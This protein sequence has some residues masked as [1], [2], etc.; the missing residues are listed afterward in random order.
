MRIIVCETKSEDKAEKKTLAELRKL[1][2]KC[3]ICG[4]KADISHDVIDGADYGYSVGCQSFHLRDGI[5]GISE[6]YDPLAPRF[7]CFSK[8]EAFKKWENY[9]KQYTN[10]KKL[11]A[12]NVFEK[13]GD[14]GNVIVF[15]P[16][17]SKAN[18]IAY[19]YFYSCCDHYYDSYY[20]FIKSTLV[21]RVKELDASYRGHNVMNWDDPQ[22]R[23][24]LVRKLGWYCL[25]E[26][27]LDCDICPASKFCNR[28]EDEE[29]LEGE[30]G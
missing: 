13:D 25:D 19:T 3:P 8:E 14:L 6:P 30:D 28:Y 17:A 7:L 2:P 11:K 21:R 10:G 23:F 29:F 22:D 20:D 9:C 18:Y 24:D 26:T 27:D 1:L 5:H 12:Y 16:K 15:A 4:G